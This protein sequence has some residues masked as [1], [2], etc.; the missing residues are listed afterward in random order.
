MSQPHSEE[1]VL[2]KTTANEKV[3]VLTSPE[4]NAGNDGDNHR[5]DS[6]SLE[7]Q[8]PTGWRLVAIAIAIILSMFLVWLH[9]LSFRIL[10]KI[11]KNVNV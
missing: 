8:H 7:M 3:A 9:Y 6:P 1:L 2:D 11:A 5:E 10:Y 4:P